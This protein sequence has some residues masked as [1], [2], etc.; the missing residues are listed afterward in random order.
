[1]TW[2]RQLPVVGAP[3]VWPPPGVLLRRWSGCC[4]RYRRLG[5]AR[6]VRHD[7][8]GELR[9][10]G[11]LHTLFHIAAR[12][13]SPHAM[14]TAMQAAMAGYSLTFAAGP[15]VLGDIVH[16]MVGVMHGV[17]FA[18]IAQYLKWRGLTL[19][20]AGIVWGLA[21]FVFNTRIGLPLAAAL[22]GD[23]HPISS[24]ASM[25][26]YPIFLIEHPLFGATL[27]ILLLERRASATDQT[28]GAIH[29]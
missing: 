12:F 28:G 6:D 21:G 16:M 3:M 5:D 20:G 18:V 25:V 15:A 17:I 22:L 23:G 29:R 24:M 8:G 11:I 13:I 1:L 2:L 7:R 4:R 10:H 9:G 14:M 19:V 27:G 26:G